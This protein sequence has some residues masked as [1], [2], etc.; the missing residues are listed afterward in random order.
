[1]TD[2][3]QKLIIDAKHIMLKSTD[4]THDFEHTRRVVKYTEEI[5]KQYSL[6]EK[7][8]QALVLSAWWHDVG[9]TIKKNPSYIWLTFLDDM[10]S[11]FMLWRTT[12]FTGFFGRVPGLATRTILCKSLGTGAFF[13]RILMGRKDRILVSI[14]EDADKLD[15][16][17]LA[18]HQELYKLIENSRLY[19]LGY[20]TMGWW[21]FRLKRIKL[22]TAAAR[23][24]FRSI[25]N[26]F[27]HWIKQ[28]SVFG[29]HVA[30]FGYDWSQ[31][32]LLRVEKL[33]FKIQCAV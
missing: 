20:R 21:F 22:K 24:I 15:L 18:R 10:I 27:L 19:K 26:N 3:I 30:N 13:T 1:M 9:R 4:P 33:V 2:K 14:I 29:W 16:F 5:S 23:E 6:T 25:M 32:N 11:S 31:K 7:Q 12:I 28:A 17:D 8:R